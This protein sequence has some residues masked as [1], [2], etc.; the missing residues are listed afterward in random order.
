MTKKLLHP[1]PK[2]ACVLI[3]GLSDAVFDCVDCR[4]IWCCIWLLIAGLSDAVFDYVLI[5]GL[6]NAVFDCWLQAYL[7]LYLTVCRLIW[8]CIWLCVDCGLIWCCIWLLIAGLSDAVF[9]CVDCRLIWCCIWLC[10]DCRLILPCVWPLC[11][12]RAYLTYCLIFML[13][14]V[15]IIW[16]HVW[17]LCWLQAY[18]TQCLAFVLIAGLS[19]PMFIFCVNCRYSNTSIFINICECDIYIFTKCVFNIWMY[20]IIWIKYL[21]IIISDPMF[22]LC[23]DCRLIWPSHHSCTWRHVCLPWVMCFV[24]L[25]LFVLNRPAHADIWLS[26]LHYHFLFPAT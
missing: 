2:K 10:V 1:D 5:A 12:L 21:V 16:P 9:D 4:L 14:A 15:L 8:C 19:N 22:D 6:S 11:W 23:F 13:I 20:I 17:P 25:S 7:M 24:W 3:A 18:L 26:K